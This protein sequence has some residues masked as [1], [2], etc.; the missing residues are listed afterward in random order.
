MVW[1]FNALYF[2]LRPSYSGI[3]PHL[4]KKKIQ[5]EEKRERDVT[6]PAKQPDP[7]MT[8]L[9][10]RMKSSIK[11]QRRHSCPKCGKLFGKPSHVKRHLFTCR[12]PTFQR[13]S[14]IKNTS[15]A[16]YK[17]MQHVM[18][19]IKFGAA[20]GGEHTSLAAASQQRRLQQ[21]QKRHVGTGSKSRS[22]QCNFLAF[23]IESME[24]LVTLVPQFL[25]LEGTNF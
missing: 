20:K 25:T 16:Y 24:D 6:L 2:D 19:S 8:K 21:L 13:T 1:T 7:L 9:K 11:G 18:N 15:A 4:I 23:G 3:E 5:R 12:G 10:E 22:T 14:P 17:Q